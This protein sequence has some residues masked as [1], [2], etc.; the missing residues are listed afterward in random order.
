MKKEE[1]QLFDSLYVQARTDKSHKPLSHLNTDHYLA[2]EK[3]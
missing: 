1:A 2:L 3:T